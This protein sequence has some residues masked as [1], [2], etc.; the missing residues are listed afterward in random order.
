M[1]THDAE[2]DWADRQGVAMAEAILKSNGAV[3]M[4]FEIMADALSAHR[5]VLRETAAMG[6]SQP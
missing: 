2:T 4:Q 1:L 3:I 5:R 6:P